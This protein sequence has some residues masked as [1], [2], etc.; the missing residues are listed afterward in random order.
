MWRETNGWT[1]IFLQIDDDQSGN[2][3][4]CH[5]SGNGNA[6]PAVEDVADGDG[7]GE[8]LPVRVR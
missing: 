7:D 5:N 1:E 3:W 2:E 8:S 6:R 4:S